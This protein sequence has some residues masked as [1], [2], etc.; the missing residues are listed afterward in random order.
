MIKSVFVTLTALLALVAAPLATASAAPAVKAPPN[1]CKSFTTNSADAL[2]GL[3]KGTAVRRELS[4]TGSGKNE[5]RICTVRQGGNKLTIN[6]SYAEGG[7]GGPLKCYKRPKLGKHGL[8]CVSTE[9]SFKIS[10]ARY[11]KHKVWFADVYNKIVPDKGAKLY[12]F[13]LAQ[14]RAF[15]G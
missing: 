8:V 5:T 9:R 12:A 2:F 7:F 13:A 11:E 10:F 15:K 1:P 14:S 6:V 3:K 4:S